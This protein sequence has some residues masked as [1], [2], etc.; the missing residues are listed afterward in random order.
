MS[1]HVTAAECRAVALARD[2][3]TRVGWYLGDAEEDGG[4]DH[5]EGLS[6]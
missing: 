5:E 1:E 4:R 2:I 3:V 6:L